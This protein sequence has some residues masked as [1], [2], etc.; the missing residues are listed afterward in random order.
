MSGLNFEGQKI[1]L[2]Q[3]ASGYVLTLRIHPDELPEELFRDFVGAR[4]GVAM[5]RIN[6]DESVVNYMNRV[7][8]SGM[9]CKNRVFWDWLEHKGYVNTKICTEDVAIK[10][11]YEICGI[12]SRT[13]LNGN[14]DAT[15]SFDKMVKDYDEWSKKEI[16]F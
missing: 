5:V 6:D 8:K 15:N 9:L 4:Y 2:K 1:A 7:K 3:D 13:E 12:S 16:G 14:K 11:L 10:V